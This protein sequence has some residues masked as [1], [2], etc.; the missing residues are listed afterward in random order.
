M[1][2]AKVARQSATASE[3][4]SN[5]IAFLVHSVR[6]AAD[7]IPLPRFLRLNLPRKQVGEHFGSRLH[8]P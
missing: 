4:G 3:I 8:R 1:V 6:N 7:L 5:K 2:A